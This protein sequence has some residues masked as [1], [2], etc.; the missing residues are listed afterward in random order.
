MGFEWDLD[1]KTVALTQGKH[2]KYIMAIREWL[3]TTVHTLEETQKL[4]G[5]LT[6]ASLVIP[7]GCAYLASLQAMLGIFRDNPFMPHRQPRGTIDKL[8]WW[9]QAL[10]G[11]PPCPI[12]H[13]PFSLNPNA[14]SDASSSHG[15][16]ITISGKWRAWR[17]HRNWKCDEQDIRWAESIVFEFLVWTLLIIDKSS[18]PLMV[19]G[20]NQGIIEAWRKG[21]NRN[22]P[23]NTTFKRILAVLVSPPCHIFANYIPSGINP[24]DG[25][26][27][28]EY[29][30]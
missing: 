20:D 15:L 29:P 30:P 24:T 22:K 12:P 8:K 3:C 5:P 7:E 10:P 6:H 27:R 14:Y 18:A 23:T 11:H 25:P 21:C 19:Y 9:L 13:H 16:A 17:L 2:D 28:G 4:H 1:Q 26:S